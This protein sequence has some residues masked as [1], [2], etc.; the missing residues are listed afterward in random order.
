[1]YKKS[2]DPI[3]NLLLLN[4]PKNVDNCSFS[5]NHKLFTHFKKEYFFFCSTSRQKCPSTNGRQACVVWSWLLSSFIDMIQKENSYCAPKPA[6]NIIMKSV[7]IPI[8][9]FRLVP[10]W[11]P[12]VTFQFMQ[13]PEWRLHLWNNG[14]LSASAEPKQSEAQSPD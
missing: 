14:S 7:Y 9:T 12:G 4:L 2:N 13:P 11:F 6:H 5:R 3:M 10:Y 1:M 8:S